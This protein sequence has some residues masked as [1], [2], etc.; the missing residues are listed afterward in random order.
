MPTR[1]EI[2]EETRVPLRAIQW[3][4][5][6]MLAGIL[7]IGGIVVAFRVDL[8]LVTERT[9]AMAESLKSIAKSVDGL[10]E[11]RSKVEVHD[12][13]LQQL[14]REVEKLQPVGK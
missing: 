5:G 14:S 2:T 8:A 4:I 10:S 6:I 13:L 1:D 3:L 12:V 9:G 7:G 11:L